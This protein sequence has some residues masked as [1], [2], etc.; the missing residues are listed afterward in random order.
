MKGTLA[1]LF[2]MVRSCLG[3]LQPMPPSAQI[4]MAPTCRVVSPLAAGSLLMF[5]A[6][7]LPRYLYAGSHPRP[8]T[9][10]KHMQRLVRRPNVRAVIRPAFQ[11]HDISCERVCNR[12]AQVMALMY[13]EA[14]KRNGGKAAVA[15][16]DASAAPLLPKDPAAV[17]VKGAVV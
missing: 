1:L 14:P 16:P 5:H 15:P 4:I 12:C 8:P 11:M 17:P 2:C 7:V 10:A 6:D 9:P 3:R 13:Q